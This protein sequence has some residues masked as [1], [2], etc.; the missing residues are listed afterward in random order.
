MTIMNFDDFDVWWRE[1]SD[2]AQLSQMRAWL[3]NELQLPPYSARSAIEYSILWRLARWHHFAAMKCADN[4]TVARE[5]F[6]SG[7]RHAKRAR[8][9]H[10]RI[11]HSTLEADFWHV[12]NALEAARLKN[13]LATL[14]VLPNATKALTNVL[15]CDEEFHFAGALRVLGRMTH[16]KPNF[17]G[18]GARKSLS[19][20]Q[21][22]LHFAPQNSTTRLYYAE[23]LRDANEIESARYQLEMLISQPLDDEWRWEQARDKIIAARLLKEPRA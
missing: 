2:D 20:F 9:S 15:R 22:A 4:I 23:A 3:E 11:G 19:W 12:V 18:G 21:D 1:R 16:L 8:A 14:C 10:Q 5:Y 13:Q 17:L 6:A 7:A